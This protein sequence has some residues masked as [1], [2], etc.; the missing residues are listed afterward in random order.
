MGGEPKGAWLPK[1][2]I[3]TPAERVPRGC[4]T[5]VA[6]FEYELLEDR[7][8]YLWSANSYE[9]ISVEE[10][11][12]IIQCEFSIPGGRSLGEEFA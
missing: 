1:G 11:S 12:F 5:Q 4:Q 6:C 8:F 7:M 3:P 10:F 9:I 2:C